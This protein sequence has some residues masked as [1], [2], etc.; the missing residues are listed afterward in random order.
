[1]VSAAMEAGDMLSKSDQLAHAASRFEDA[2]KF[3]GKLAEANF[4]DCKKRGPGKSAVIL[5]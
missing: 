1:M 5:V 2:E 3:A 4:N